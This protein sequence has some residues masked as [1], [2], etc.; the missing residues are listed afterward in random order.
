MT[1]PNIPHA[2]TCRTPRSA[3]VQERVLWESVVG[4]MYKRVY[5]CVACGE[6]AQIERFEAFE[7]EEED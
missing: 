3:M 2:N 1:T 6:T 5:G 7:V 4:K